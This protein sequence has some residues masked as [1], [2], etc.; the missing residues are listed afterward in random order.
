MKIASKIIKFL[1]ENKIKYKIVN[2][3]T[4]YTAYDVAVTM[5]KKLGEVAK[6]LLVLADK[7]YFLVVVPA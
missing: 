7:N 4:V 2:H 6:T 1:D 3:K 5:K